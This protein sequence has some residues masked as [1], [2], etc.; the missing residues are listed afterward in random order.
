MDVSEERRALGDDRVNPPGNFIYSGAEID[1]GIESYSALCAKQPSV[2]LALATSREYAAHGEAHSEEL[3]RT[4]NQAGQRVDRDVPWVDRFD[5]GTFATGWTDDPRLVDRR[6]AWR[7]ERLLAPIAVTN[8][9]LPQS[10]VWGEFAS[11]GMADAQPV[12]RYFSSG[13]DRG[14]II[15]IPWGPSSGVQGPCARLAGES[16]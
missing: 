9:S 11:I 6:R 13:A 8:M 15:G 10:F 14:S 16:E 7:P 12:D 3:A 2:A 4:A 1:Q 5:C